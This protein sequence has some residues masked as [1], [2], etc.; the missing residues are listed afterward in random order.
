MSLDRFLIY[1]SE[2]KLNNLA[3]KTKL[4]DYNKNVKRTQFKCLKHFSR[5][6]KTSTQTFLQGVP[7]IDVAN[8]LWIRIPYTKNAISFKS[9]IYYR[10]FKQDVKVYH[11]NECVD[12]PE[13]LPPFHFSSSFLIRWQV[14]IIFLH[15]VL[16]L[17]I[18]DS[19]GWV[20]F[21]VIM[22]LA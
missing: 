4:I 2:M 7:V 10:K 16:L 8:D 15:N 9:E 1:H 3:L 12:E 13:C 21:C 18:W 6:L 22:I 14:N 11:E 5:L 19:E 20:Y 17:K